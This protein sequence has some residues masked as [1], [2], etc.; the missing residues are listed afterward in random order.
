MRSVG[1]SG[2]EVSRRGRGK[3]HGVRFTGQRPEDE[4]FRRPLKK[5]KK[6]LD[7]NRL[8]QDEKKIHSGAFL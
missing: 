4:T 6:L 8:W 2:N 3:W 5:V 1:K 7:E